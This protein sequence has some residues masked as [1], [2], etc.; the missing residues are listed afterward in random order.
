M[1]LESFHTKARATLAHMLKEAPDTHPEDLLDAYADML[2]RLH[3]AE[4]HELFGQVLDDARTRL[5][6]RLSPDPLTQGIASVQTTMQ[7]L[8]RSFWQD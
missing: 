3:A 4:A 2:T 7:D 6:A 5:D 8:W 1:S